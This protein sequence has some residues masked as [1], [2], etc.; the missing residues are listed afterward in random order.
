MDIYSNKSDNESKEILSEEY[1][2]DLLF[3][4]LK[5]NNIKSEEHS[6][7]QDNYFKMLFRDWI[8]KDNRKWIQKKKIYLS[9]GLRRW[10][11][12]KEIDLKQKKRI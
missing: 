11:R 6:K 3:D 1:N 7:D 10:R 9:K 2:I 12:N 5:N 8:K 4:E